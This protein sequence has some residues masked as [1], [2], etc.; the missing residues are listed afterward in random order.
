MLLCCFRE[1][2]EA[3]RSKR[4]SAAA[5][6]DD[7][8]PA[9]YGQS[10]SQKR[11]LKTTPATPIGSMSTSSGNNEILVASV[12][13]HE[14]QLQ[15]PPRPPSSTAAMA[16]PPTAAAAGHRQSLCS[17]TSDRSRPPSRDGSDRR[18]P[19][20]APMPKEAKRLFKQRSQES[21]K[22]NNKSV[23]S[24]PYIDASPPSVS[25]N[26]LVK[27]KASTNHTTPTHCN[28]GWSQVSSSSAAGGPGAA[29]TPNLP[30]STP[31][32][33]AI[34]VTSS[35]RPSVSKITSETSLTSSSTSQSHLLS[36]INGSS[37]QLSKAEEK[38]QGRGMCRSSATYGIQ[39][40]LQ[41]QIS[42]EEKESQAKLIEREVKAAVAK[43]T[44]SYEERLSAARAE[45]SLKIQQVLRE[46]TTAV[47]NARNTFETELKRQLATFEK[48]L[49]DL[50]SQHN[51]DLQKRDHM[52]V[53]KTRDREEE[54]HQIIAQ[55]EA[56]DEAW[57]A[58]KAEVLS[59]IQR[60]KEEANRFISILAE[61][62]DPEKANELL[63][64]GK[65][66]SLTREVESLQLVVEMRTTELHRL[67]EERWRHLQQLDQ[68]EK[69]KDLLEKANARVEDL[70]VQ[71]AAKTELERQLSWENSKL[72]NFFETESKNKSRISMQVEE[73]QWRIKH[74]KELPP[75]QVFSPT[76]SLSTTGDENSPQ[77]VTSS[78]SPASATSAASSSAPPPPPSSHQWHTSTPTIVMNNGVQ[79]P[80]PRPKDE[81]Y[82]NK[83]EKSI[84]TQMVRPNTI[85]GIEPL[86][87]DKTP[88]DRNGGRKRSTTGSQDSLE[89]LEVVNHLKDYN[90][91]GRCDLDDEE[92]G[93]EE[94]ADQSKDSDDAGL[95]DEG[96]G[97]ITSEASNSPQPPPK[98]QDALTNNNDNEELEE[99]DSYLHPLPSRTSPKSVNSENSKK[100]R[101][102]CDNLAN[103]V[104]K[105]PKK[106]PSQQQPPQPSPRSNN[107]YSLPTSPCDE[108]V[109]SRM[110]FQ[111]KSYTNL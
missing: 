68:L 95:S 52:F 27:G 21:F 48:D 82:V 5:G 28:K 76:T 24:I 33:Q 103:I 10:H 85:E 110:V 101:L 59:E 43:V 58:E 71:L 96:L 73:L 32:H 81:V 4:A 57:Q 109:P 13:L 9:Y 40:L 2:K 47:N 94:K 61:E 104:T 102:H 64:P 86:N 39:Q 3:K 25:S 84:T 106:Q 83:N 55:Y 26:G 93:Q 90:E 31:K 100:E 41:E 45:H 105:E 56:R 16:P 75:P 15:P 78:V 38:I 88:V 87:L 53:A 97:D 50:K 54:Q 34:Y 60:L 51:T 79:S 111:H 20:R 63:S 80:S 8:S 42:R 92:E 44:A 23:T 66:Q 77:C 7:I 49:H 29:S 108:R 37:S 19:E 65:R 74:N 72:E 99:H 6:A 36:Q 67:R 35:I 69:T 30:T 11:P 14:Q 1:P 62:D 98:D 18:L 17:Y 89:A 12:T 107:N 46:K 70:T 91:N 22:D